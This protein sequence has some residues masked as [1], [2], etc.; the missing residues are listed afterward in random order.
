MSL[1]S[2]ARRTTTDSHTRRPSCSARWPW[3]SDSDRGSALLEVAMT[4]P[5]ILLVSVAIFEFGRLFQ[6]WEVLGNAARE[7]ARVAILPNTPNGGAETTARSYMRSGHLP[8]FAS[9]S[10]NVSAVQIPIGGGATATA[11]RVTIDYPFQFMVLQPVARLI[12]PSTSLGAAIT[13]RT[14]V[15]MRNETQF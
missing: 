3:R 6:T 7:G 11:S 10:V 9:A 5:L 1:K 8:N 12:T 15:E 13:V 4:L 2:R 14:S